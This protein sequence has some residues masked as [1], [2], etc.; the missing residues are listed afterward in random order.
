M[1]TT[2]QD[3]LVLEVTAIRVEQ[4]KTLPRRL[5]VS[6]AGTVQSPG[7][8]NPQL[9]PYTY[10]QAPPDGIYDYDF[11]ATPPTDVTSK[12]ITPI[13]LRTELPAEGVNGLRIHATQNFLEEVFD[14]Y[15]APVS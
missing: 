15:E 6:V 12:A 3:R 1:N 9:V 13:R 10:V 11:V 4:L 8:S 2:P 7:W 14:Q 5:Q